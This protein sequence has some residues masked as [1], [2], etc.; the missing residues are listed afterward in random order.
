MSI[1]PQH[2]QHSPPSA[3]VLRLGRSKLWTAV[4]GATVLLSFFALLLFGTVFLLA[5]TGGE[6]AEPGHFVLLALELLIGP[7]GVYVFVNGWRARHQVLVVDAAGVWWHDG[8]GSALI[9]WQSLAAAGIWHSKSGRAHA[10]T[11]E[12]LPRDAIDRDHPLLWPLVREEA[13]V[14]HAT[15]HLPPGLPPMR[16][17]I[18]LTWRH[19]EVSSAVRTYAPHLWFGEIRR[20]PGHLDHPDRRGHRRRTRRRGSAD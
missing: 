12:L 17:R 2:P 7:F 10:Y 4:W 19:S 11:L 20:P 5:R 13:P 14:V 18:P 16:Y 3:T 8:P 6:G 9:P 15:M 1:E